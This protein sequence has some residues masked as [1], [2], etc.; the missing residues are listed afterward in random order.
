MVPFRQYREIKHLFLEG[1]NWIFTLTLYLA[2][3]HVIQLWM[4]H[5]IK[6]VFFVVQRESGIS[7]FSFEISCCSPDFYNM[8]AGCLN[9]TNFLFCELLFLLEA[10]CQVL[11][12]FV[13]HTFCFIWCRIYKIHHIFYFSLLARSN[14]YRL[15]FCRFVILNLSEGLLIL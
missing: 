15:L 4:P 2:F 10:Q 6:M 13:D 5:A 1:G 3:S 12:V 7:T 9:L 11:Q 14:A 8:L